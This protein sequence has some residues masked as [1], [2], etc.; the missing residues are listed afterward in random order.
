M[1]VAY[2]TAVDDDQAR[3]VCTSRGNNVTVVFEA[4]GVPPFDDD[5]NAVTAVCALTGNI[6]EMSFDRYNAPQDPASALSYGA[7]SFIDGS[8]PKYFLTRGIPLAVFLPVVLFI[9]LL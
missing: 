9:H 4:A 5:K 3:R 1:T 6:P 8:T 2:S 7:G